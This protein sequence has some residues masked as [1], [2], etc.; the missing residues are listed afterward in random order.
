MAGARVVHAGERGRACKRA[1]ANVPPT[2]CVRTW[3]VACN[4]IGRKFSRTEKSVIL[5]LA[6]VFVVFVCV[7]WSRNQIEGFLLVEKFQIEDAMSELFLF[8]LDSDTTPGNSI[9]TSQTQERPGMASM[10]WEWEWG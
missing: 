1:R 7:I 2:P 9:Q 4:L 8:V 10:E 6:V 3:E 5:E